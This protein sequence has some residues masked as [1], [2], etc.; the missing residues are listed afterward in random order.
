MRDRAVWLLLLSV[1]LLVGSGS[2]EPRLRE[3]AREAGA[4][5]RVIFAGESPDGRALMSAMDV[6]A[7]P[8]M[9]ETFGVAVVEAL[10]SGLPVLYGTCPAVEDLA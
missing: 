9:E 4:E 6:L 3:L 5:H 7:A 10:A 8:S 1:L 2:C